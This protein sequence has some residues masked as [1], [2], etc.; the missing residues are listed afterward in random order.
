MVCSS[1]K[2][3]ISLETL[4]THF[5]PSFQYDSYTKLHSHY[6]LSNYNTL[7][8][9]KLFRKQRMLWESVSLMIQGGELVE[10][11]TRGKIFKTRSGKRRMGRGGEAEGVLLAGFHSWAKVFTAT[12]Q[13]GSAGGRLTGQ[14]DRPICF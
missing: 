6:I 14:T 3:E 12:K 5:S 7:A 8:A 2:A 9:T 11:K 1:E 13:L 4:L 10:M